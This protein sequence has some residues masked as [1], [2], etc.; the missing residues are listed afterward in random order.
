MGSVKYHPEINARAYATATLEERQAEL[1]K[2]ERDK[3]AARSTARRAELA[4][5]NDELLR[6][7]TNAGK[8]FTSTRKSI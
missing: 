7:N 2:V 3:K 6:R 5:I 4:V 1:D 8:G